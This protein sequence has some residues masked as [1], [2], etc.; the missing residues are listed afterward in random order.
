VAAG[1]SVL[2]GE[3][4]SL[5][6][7]LTIAVWALV[8]LICSL[9]AWTLASPLGSGP[10]EP[11][12]MIQAAATVR[13][14]VAGP[15]ARVPFGALFKVTVPQWTAQAAALPNCFAFRPDQP[16]GCSPPVG[17]TGSPT[18]S[19]TQFG[20]YPPLYYAL[21][22]L[23]SLGIPGSR[24]LYAMRAVAVVLDSCLLALG[25]FVLV[26][27]GRS[28]LRPLGALVALTPMVLFVTSVVNDSGIEVAAAFAAWCALVTMADGVSIPRAL[29][30]WAALAVA[31]LMVSRPTSLLDAALLA[32]VIAAYAGWRR[33]QAIV[34]DRAAWPVLGMGVLGGVMAVAW[35]LVAGSP[36]LLGYP[37]RPQRNLVGSVELVVGESGGRLRQL[38]GDFGWLDTPVPLRDVVVWATI[39]GVL[40]AVGL[41]RSSAVRRS[42]PLLLLGTF[43][44]SLAIETPRVNAIGPFWQGRYWLPLAVGVPLLACA[45]FATNFRGRHSRRR[46]RWQSV[47]LV[48]AVGTVLAL[49]QIDALVTALRRYEVGLGAPVGATAHW[50][51][52]GGD[53]L[54]LSLAIVGQAALV[55]LVAWSVWRRPQRDTSGSDLPDQALFDPGPSDDSGKAVGPEV[56]PGVRGARP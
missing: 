49:V 39:V 48:V 51:P 22:G 24:G 40:V 5:T 54:V 47:A 4:S 20:N 9:T 42:V 46:P 45:P 23:P 1:A 21:V 35:L 12:H 3:H 16:A 8:G 11:S 50:A 32:L 28:R 7:R 2:E 41:L 53:A 10:D 25:L 17:T 34:A 26:R 6:T 43:A 13:G 14:E 33:T 38:V 37:L 27:Y 44:M 19:T 18:P 55:S 29:G 56:M 36:T 30:W 52:P 15:S 31:L